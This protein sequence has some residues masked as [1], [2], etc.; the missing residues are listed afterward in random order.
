MERGGA[1]VHSSLELRVSNGWVLVGDQLL[2][3]PQGIGLFAAEGVEVG[4]EV[5]KVPKSLSIRASS[6]SVSSVESV[7]PAPAKGMAVILATAQVLWHEVAAGAKSRFSAYIACLPAECPLPLCGDPR[8]VA[9]T[10]DPALVRRVRGMREAIL[11]GRTKMKWGGRRPSEEEWLWAVGMV[12]S[13]SNTMDSGLEIIPGWDF[14]NHAISGHLRGYPEDSTFKAF[15][16]REAPPGGELRRDYFRPYGKA[17]RTSTPNTVIL[18]KMGFSSRNDAHDFLLLRVPGLDDPQ[19]VDRRLTNNQ[20]RPFREVAASELGMSVQGMNLS[21]VAPAAI[22]ERALTIL[23]DAVQ[24]TT[25]LPSKKWERGGRPSKLFVESS[26]L[27]GLQAAN[28]IGVLSGVALRLGQGRR[29]VGRSC[30]ESLRASGLAWPVHTVQRAIYPRFSW[31]GY[32]MRALP[33]HLRQE[34]VGAW[35]RNEKRAFP[36]EDAFPKVEGQVVIRA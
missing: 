8:D 4:G 28:V 2:S 9:A 27:W 25:V 34:L 26:R 18:Q 12:M 13:R 32:S 33:R 22:E 23:S 3:R 36:E 17:S 14:V 19:V 15:S 29:W 24:K 21:H 10:G 35:H 31:S 7:V 6:T 20:L 30:S 5:L 1:T 11:D 16:G